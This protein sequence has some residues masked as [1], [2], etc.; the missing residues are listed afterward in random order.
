MNLPLASLTFIT[1][2]LH[3]TEAQGPSYE[4]ACHKD[5][6]ALANTCKRANDLCK[7]WIHNRRFERYTENLRYD[8]LGFVNSDSDE[9]ESDAS[10]VEGDW[11][12]QDSLLRRFGFLHVFPGLLRHDVAEHDRA[13][14]QDPA[15]CLH[16]H[17][18]RIRIRCR[19]D[20]KGTGC[21]TGHE[22]GQAQSNGPQ[23]TPTSFPRP[24]CHNEVECFE[25]GEEEEEFS[26]D[27]VEV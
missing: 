21:R 15:P 26:E 11:D 4:L 19:V 6:F 8:T 20:A 24:V 18:H 16:F 14:R 5:M 27:D 25:E 12:N 10:S 3:R 2:L 7:Q 22:E 9:A 1:E 17:R 13:G 23:G